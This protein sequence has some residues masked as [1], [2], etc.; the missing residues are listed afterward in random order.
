MSPVSWRELYRHRKTVAE[1]RPTVYGLPR[2]RR[3][4]RLAEPLLRP[5][6]RILEVGP[7]ADRRGARLAEGLPG[8]SIVEVDPDPAA[9]G[10]SR[11]EDVAGPFDLALALEVVEHLPLDE[12]VALLD[13]IRERLAPGGALLLSTPNVYC[14]GRFLRDATHVTPFAYD[15]LGGV[16]LMTGYEIEGIYRV[17]PGSVAKRLGRRLLFPLFLALGID[18]APSVAAVARRPRAKP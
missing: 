13:A 10:P 6:L 4:L 7:G 12:A 18:H 5:G 17:V 16:L 9:T 2:I 15:E 3:A 8:S 14:P 11:I 1:H